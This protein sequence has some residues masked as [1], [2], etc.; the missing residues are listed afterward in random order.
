MCLTD[1]TEKSS[2][3]YYMF[4]IYVCVNCL[5]PSYKSRYR[6]IYR[7]NENDLLAS[8]LRLDQYYVV[9]NYAFDYQTRR[10]NYTTIYLNPVGIDDAHLGLK[11]ILDQD[12]PVCDLDIVIKLPYHDPV[13]LKQKLQTC[14]VFS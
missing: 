7:I 4:D 10:S 6:E 1:K 14:V 3:F 8:T 12:A 13:A 9:L 11:P 2:I 5:L